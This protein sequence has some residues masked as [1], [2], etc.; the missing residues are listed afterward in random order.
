[1]VVDLAN[2]TSRSVARTGCFDGQLGANV[3]WGTSDS[4]LLYNDLRWD[5]GKPHAHAIRLDP[6]SGEKAELEGPVYMVSHDGAK[7]ASPCL[8]RM[9]LTQPGYGA[10]I[11]PSHL[12]YNH[13]ASVEDGIFVT[14]VGTGDCKLFISIGEIVSDI[15]HE[16]SEAFERCGAIL[17]ERDIYGFHVKW[18]A[19]DDRLLFVMRARTG[20]P[21]D[22]LI[23]FV[24]TIE[25]ETRRACLAMPPDV[26]IRG[27]HHPDWQPDGEHI[28][29]NLKYPGDEMRFVQYSF[30]G[31]G[32]E[33][34]ACDAH[35]GGHPTLHPNARYILTDEYEH[36]PLAYPDGTTPIRLVEL[37]TGDVREIIRMRTRPDYHGPA[38]EL[39]VD[40]HPAWDSTYRYI[41]FN[42]CPEGTRRIFV[43]DVEPLMS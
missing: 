17:A 30:D 31:S 25:V 22:R 8:L 15:E 26:W 23:N 43:A 9:P 28:I 34:I 5:S 27:G 1:V 29:M 13:G 18:N 32:L 11:L 4:D 39:R 10:V 2:G 21:R 40:P 24:V 33:T 12:P 14:D 35:G 6:E 20:N 42:G 7:I 3:Q 38:R 41:A 37:A 16:L 19:E 36:G